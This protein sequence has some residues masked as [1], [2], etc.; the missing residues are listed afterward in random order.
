M[1]AWIRVLI[2]GMRDKELEVDIG[3]IINRSYSKLR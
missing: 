3:G 2:L 1:V